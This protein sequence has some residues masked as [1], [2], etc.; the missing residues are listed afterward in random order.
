MVQ[1]QFMCN[2]QLNPPQVDN[3]NIF[4]TLLKTENSVIYDSKAPNDKRG[5][6]SSL[7]YGYK[8]EVIIL[9]LSLSFILR[10]FNISY[11]EALKYFITTLQLFAAKR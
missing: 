8:H 6:L 1:L 4:L 3:E 9:K 5:L 11:V 2:M 10:P 7:F